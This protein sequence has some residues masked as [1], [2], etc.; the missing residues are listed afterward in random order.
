MQI[1][2]K[3]DVILNAATATVSATSN[4]VLLDGIKDYS[5][6]VDFS[7]ASLAGTLKLQCS[8]DPTA[9]SAPST[10]DWVDVVSSSQSITSA[11]SYLFNQISQNY[12][13]VRVTFTGSGG[14]G[15]MTAWFVA[16]YYGN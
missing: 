7:G 3:K 8:N 1:R 4:P 16:K 13:A 11:G 12:G 14:T 6:H 9:I 2:V 10:A 15:T 5:I